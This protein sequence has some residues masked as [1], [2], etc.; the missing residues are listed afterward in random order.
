MRVLNAVQRVLLM[1][2]LIP[3][4][5]ICLD[6]LLR[7]FGAQGSNPIVAAIRDV[8]NFFIIEPFK[9]V[10]P[11][12]TYWQDALVALAAFGVLAL[13]IRFIFR[14]LR[15]MVGTRPP[16]VRTSAQPAGTPAPK[17]A[18]AP[19]KAEASTAAEASTGDDTT[20]TSP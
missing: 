12:Q 3:V 19:P 20:S 4:I 13:V 8:A 17:A 10:F 5:A 9:T 15:A 11:N 6:T 16:T 18:P 1:L 2:V 14:G 7:A